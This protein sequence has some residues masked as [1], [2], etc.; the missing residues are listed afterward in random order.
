MAASLPQ[1]ETARIEALLQYKILDTKPEETFDQITRLASYI[2]GTP[3]ALISLIDTNRQWF[4]SKV[5]LETLETSRD[6]AFC[7]HAILQKDIFMVSDATTD[8]R[9]TNNPLVTS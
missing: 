5:G 1:D 7:A 6:L 4:K 8:E 2:C 3:I 9:F